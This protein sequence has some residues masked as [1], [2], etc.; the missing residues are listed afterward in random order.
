[1]KKLLAFLALTTCYLLLTG[2]VA[3]ADQY[4]PPP[5]SISIMIEKKVGMPAAKASDPTT[6]NYVNNLSPTDP[7]FHAGDDVNFRIR[8]KNTSNIHQHVTVRDFITPHISPSAGPGSFDGANRII[9]F[10]AG[11]FAPNEERIFYI[12]TVVNAENTFPS[13]KNLFCELNRAEAHAD[14]PADDSSYSQFCIERAAAAA[15][16]PTKIPLKGAVIPPNIPS[17]GP[18][19]GIALLSGEILALGFGLLIRKK[20]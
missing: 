19:L 18:E 20:A 9:S 7:R 6:L 14:D 4:G 3:F 17:T 1:M 12:T 13:D 11:T 15:P 8:I 16:V 5:P 2:N 10:D